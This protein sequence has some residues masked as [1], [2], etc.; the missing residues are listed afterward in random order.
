MGIADWRQLSMGP[1][2]LP[3][4]DRDASRRKMPTEAAPRLLRAV[5]KRFEPQHRALPDIGQ[6]EF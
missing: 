4:P 5:N 2:Q 1:Q 6:I 3:T